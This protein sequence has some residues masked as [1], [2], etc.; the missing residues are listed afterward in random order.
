MHGRNFGHLL[1]G[2]AR[3][4]FVLLVALFMANGS[5]GAETSGSARGQALDRVLGSQGLRGARVSALVVRQH[6]GAVLYARAPDQ[7]LIPASNAKV[8]TALAALDA[9]GPTHRFETSVFVSAPLGAQGRAGDL[10]LVGGGDPAIT[11][12]DWWR[13]AAE[14]REAGLTAVEGDVVVDDALFDRVRQ[15]PSVQGV[16]SR[17][18]HA[19][20]GAL[21]ANYGSFSVTVAPGQA[22]GQPVRVTLTPPVPYLRIS[23]GAKTL[24]KSRRRTLVVDRSAVEGGERVSIRGGVR[25]GD[26]PKTYYRSVVAPDLY[27]GHVLR[28]QLEAVGIRVTGAVRRGSRPETAVALHVYEGRPVGEIVRLFMKFSNNAIAEALVKNLAVLAHGGAGNWGEGIPELRR[29]LLALGV[30]AQGFALVDGSGLSYENRVAPRALVAA[31]RAGVASFRL[32]PEFMASFPIAARDGTLEERALEARDLARAKT[33][34]LNRVTGLSGYATIRVSGG[35][36]R[37]RVVFSVL[38]ND[39]RHGDQAAMDALD[40][41]VAVL[42]DGPKGF[43]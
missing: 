1:V 8:L 5:A 34:L 11:S 4:A 20:V 33:G 28:M 37:E 27:A 19:P 32:A 43:E 15:H 21:T 2:S 24:A 6:D 30:P 40:R 13:L 38:A 41:F 42:T 16:S 17:A 36:G 7:M 25:I 22:V 23:N 18:Y 39:T 31:L 12:E 9:F 35:T 14:L 29:R 26:Q 3:V 10:I